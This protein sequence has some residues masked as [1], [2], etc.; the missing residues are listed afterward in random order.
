MGFFPFDSFFALNLTTQTV[1]RIKVGMSVI[2]E[3]ERLP[4]PLFLRE[5]ARR[6][7]F[8][9]DWKRFLQF[10]DLATLVTRINESG[11]GYLSTFLGS[12]AVNRKIAMAGS[13]IWSG[14]Q[15][16]LLMSRSIAER[17]TCAISWG[18]RCLVPWNLFWRETS[19]SHLP[20]WIRWMPFC[21][22]SSGKPC[23]IYRK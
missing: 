13:S 6:H 20:S 1:H 11:C 19:W 23:S 8:S 10:Y 3:I 21:Q 22:R 7:V 16:S 14:S 4:L 17:S 2:D 9:E 12:R 18:S 5:W 15:G